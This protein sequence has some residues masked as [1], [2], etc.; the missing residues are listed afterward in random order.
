M[1]NNEIAKMITDMGFICDN[2]GIYTNGASGYWSNLS[3]KENQKFLEI[4]SDAPPEEAVRKVI[5][6]FFDMIYSSKREAALE[7]LDH[8]KPGICIDYGCMWG[9]LS[10]GMA[11]R[12]HS[13][14]AVDQTYESLCFL[15]KR[16]LNENEKKI[17]PVQTD[18]RKFELSGVADFAIV[19]GVLE[20]IPVNENV[21]VGDYYSKSK[22]M[23]VKEEEPMFMQKEFLKNVFES[24][25][26]GGKLMLAIE[27]RFSYEYFLGKKDPHANILF[28]TFL[29]R[30]ISDIISRYRKNRPY[31][32]YVYSF[33]ALKKMVSESGY[34]NV[35]LYSAFPNY[36]FPEL[37]LDYSEEGIKA[38][39]K[40]P[41]KRR[42]THKQKIAYYIEFFLMQIFKVKNLSPAIILIAEK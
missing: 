9:V 38:Y 27:N 5:P 29:P 11:K 1:I 15:Q 21:N 35:Y 16:S 26:S 24:L 22:A 34:K 41:N 20:W 25:K 33:S 39:K 17:I 19:N 2:N 40:Y 30:R 8:S 4:L 6:Q 32:N 10:F 3:V 28:T 12:G 18:I 14:I 7:F 23:N 42:I 36:H 31:R 13:V 37:I